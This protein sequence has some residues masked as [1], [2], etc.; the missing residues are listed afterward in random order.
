MPFDEKFLRETIEV[1]SDLSPEPLTMA[2][3]QEIA[4]SMTGLFSALARCAQETKSSKHQKVIS[5]SAPHA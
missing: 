5:P 3:E 4:E 1:W 2:D